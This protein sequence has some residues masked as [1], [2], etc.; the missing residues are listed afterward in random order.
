MI[1]MKIS[2]SVLAAAIL[3][4]AGCATQL[5]DAGSKVRVVTDPQH[6][7]CAFVRHVNVNARTGMDKAGDALKGALNETAA[8][9]GNR[10]YIITNTEHWANG[11]TVAGEALKCPG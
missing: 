2:S 9:G 4:L 1:G 11:A 8:A 7:T 5:T 3:G 10:L 6:G